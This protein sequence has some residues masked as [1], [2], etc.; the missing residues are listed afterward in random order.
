VS[1]CT[2]NPDGALHED[3]GAPEVDDANPFAES[4]RGAVEPA[5]ETPWNWCPKCEQT[6]D[7]DMRTGEFRDGS[8]CTCI[9]CRT[10]Y[11][12]VSYTDGSWSL[13]KVDVSG[14]ESVEPEPAPV[15]TPRDAAVARVR[16]TLGHAG[17]KLEAALGS[18]LI[19]GADA[20]DLARAVMLVAEVLVRLDKAV[21]S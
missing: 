19:V 10:V 3:C 8:E 16:Q 11:V 9:G 17:D 15:A 5:T 21:Q 20:L 14:D 18:D 2:R 12:A 1:A 6:V 13:C 4:E 7:D